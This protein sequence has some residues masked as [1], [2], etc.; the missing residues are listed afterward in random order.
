[1]REIAAMLKLFVQNV[2][3]P[4]LCL[5]CYTENSTHPSSVG[6]SCHTAFEAIFDVPFGQRIHDPWLMA[7]CVRNAKIGGRHSAIMEGKACLV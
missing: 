4:G 6:A 5:S 7:L 3:M 2:A 1:M